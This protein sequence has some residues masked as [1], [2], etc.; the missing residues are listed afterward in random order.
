MKKTHVSLKN[1]TGTSYE[2]GTQIGE[3]ILAS[4]ELLQRALLP[5]DTYPHDNFEC[6]TERFTG[7]EHADSE[8]DI[9]FPII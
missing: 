6:Y 5:P 2:V 8:I 7:A 9:Y 3:W 1:F 4:P